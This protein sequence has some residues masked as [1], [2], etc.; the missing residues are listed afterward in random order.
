MVRVVSQTP[1]L[2]TELYPRPDIPDT[3]APPP[4]LE[5]GSSIWVWWTQV[6]RLGPSCNRMCR[7]I[8]LPPPPPP[9]QY[10]SWM[11]GTVTEIEGNSVSVLYDDGDA[12]NHELDDQFVYVA[13]RGRGATPT[14]SC[15]SSKGDFGGH[16]HSHAIALAAVF[17][18]GRRLIPP[19][20]RLPVTARRWRLRHL[21][22]LPD[23]ALPCRRRPT[24]W[25]S[26]LTP[27]TPPRQTR[28]RRCSRKK[29]VQGV[30]GWRHRRMR[31]SSRG[32]R[33]TR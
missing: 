17:R 6:S 28:R 10:L 32:R 21:L 14:F 5:V 1:R 26:P 23:P 31:R 33:S 2:A 15:L 16:H 30:G 18:I 25:C 12:L 7:S 3:P 20:T 9:T 24:C 13:V 4:P 19:L 8:T 11:S 22:M 29:W 27:P